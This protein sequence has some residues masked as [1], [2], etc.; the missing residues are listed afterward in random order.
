MHAGEKCYKASDWSSLCLELT[1]GLF[2][3]GHRGEGMADAAA[4]VRGK[5]NSLSQVERQVPAS[6]WF[7]TQSYA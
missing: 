1:T 7:D 3:L 5:P 4:F 2:Q 6:P